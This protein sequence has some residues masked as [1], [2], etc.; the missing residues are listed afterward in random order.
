MEN[1]EKSHNRCTPQQTACDWIRSKQ[2][3][4][5]GYQDTNRVQTLWKITFKVSQRLQVKNWSW[6]EGF[7]TVERSRGETFKFSKRPVKGW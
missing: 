1:M 3:L 5:I 7:W 6:T 2:I 4:A